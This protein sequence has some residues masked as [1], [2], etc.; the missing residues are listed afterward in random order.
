MSFYLYLLG[1]SISALL[2][3][4]GLFNKVQSS[5]E[6]YSKS[7]VK[8]KC[9]L[10]LVEYTIE[11]A[12]EGNLDFSKFLAKNLQVGVAQNENNTYSFLLGEWQV[13]MDEYK[14]ISVEK[15]HL[16]VDKI[17]P[18]VA[19]MKASTELADGQLVQTEGYWNKSYGGGAYY[20][21]VNTTNL[22][23]DNAKCIQLDNGL[24]AELHVIND[25][26]T[27]NQFGA[28]GDLEHDDAQ[29]IQLA[30]NSG[31]KNISFESENYNINDF[32]AFSTSNIN[33]L[34]N[35]AKLVMQDGFQL[36]GSYDWAFFLGGTLE[37]PITNVN[38]YNLKIETGN[39]NFSRGD[40]VQLQIEHIKNC[41]IYN[42]EF[43]VS[44]IDR[45]KARPT[46]NI[47]ITGNNSNIK[48]NNCKIINLSNSNKGGSIWISD[49]NDT[50][51][52]AIEISNNYIE[53]S[54]HDETIAVWGGTIKNVI[55]ENNEFNIHEENVD[56]PS[57]MNF[58]FGN[59]GGILQNLVFSNNKVY[60]ESKNYFSFIN[61]ANES[62]SISIKNNNIEWI[63]RSS[64]LSYVPVFSNNS[65]VIIEISGNNIIYNTINEDSPG[66]YNFVGDNEYF[67][68]NNITINGKLQIFQ[69][70]DVNNPLNGLNSKLDS[71]NIIINTDIFYL[72]SGYYFCN[73]TV[74]L[75]GFSNNYSTVFRCSFQ[76]KKDMKILN[77]T[78]KLNDNSN[79]YEADTIKFLFCQDPT[80]NN[81]NIDI[82]NNKILSDINKAQILIFVSNA[83]DT[84]PQTIYCNNNTYNNFKAVY[85]YSNSATHKVIVNGKEITSNTILK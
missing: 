57:D 59:S 7:E 63:L 78:I 40:V 83:S 18:S 46:T 62:S 67:Y 72:Y 13:V 84:T 19:S 25:T 37:T 29:A 17:S 35:S 26:I 8:E 79:Y 73:N 51:I 11:K 21:I 70:M 36:S 4:N 76:M 39:I 52:D 55:I 20:D 69:C 27:V 28:Y 3:E 74:E 44:E 33:V 14:V 2:G 32:I 5:K 47:W 16:D 56:D 31:Y 42:C 50:N 65:S 49:M 54:S 80:F 61:P 41:E 75:K 45:S 9:S 30:L 64:S 24:Y 71:N 10:L 85:F 60:C 38:L 15:F 58:T 81:Y 34:G 68:N 23:V 43:L 53:K 1:T 77:N 48:I 6:K 82:S 22:T 66:V 12:S